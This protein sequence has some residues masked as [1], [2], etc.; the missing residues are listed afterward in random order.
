MQILAHGMTRW[1]A[2]KTIPNQTAV[3]TTSL[4]GD[5]A[6]SLR[7]VSFSP[8]CFFERPQA[9]RLTKTITTMPRP[10]R[11]LYCDLYNAKVILEALAEPIVIN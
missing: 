3:E 7:H 10:T 4:L 11:Y 6:L 9:A 8:E 2:V 1:I 5:F